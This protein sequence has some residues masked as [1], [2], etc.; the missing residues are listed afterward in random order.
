MKQ[1]IVPHVKEFRARRLRDKEGVNKDAE[2]Q[3]LESMRK[4]DTEWETQ[5]DRDAWLREEFHV[6]Y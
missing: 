1:T 6:P 4:L 3:Y 2:E 5:S